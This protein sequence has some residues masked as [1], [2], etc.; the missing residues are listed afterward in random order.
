MY[1]YECMYVCIYTY[2]YTYIYI[3][4]T[5]FCIIAKWKEKLKKKISSTKNITFSRKP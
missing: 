5:A 3:V 4:S 1:V 2:M